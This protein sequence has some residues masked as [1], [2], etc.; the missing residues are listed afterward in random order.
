MAWTDSSIW[1]IASAVLVAAELLTG[2]FYFLAVGVAFAAAGFCAAIGLSLSIQLLVAALLGLLAVAGLRISKF[3][4]PRLIMPPSI[5]VGQQVQVV[6]WRDDG[7]ARVNYRGSQ[8]DAELERADTP[9][10]PALY[11]VAIR[12]SVLILGD[13]RQ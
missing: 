3:R 9:K 4:R 2:T 11:I 8:W 6:Q 13:Q 5:D 1:W 12:G 10:S 7:T